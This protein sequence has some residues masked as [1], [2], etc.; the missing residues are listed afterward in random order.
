MALVL[1]GNETLRLPFVAQQKLFLIIIKVC[2]WE[3]LRQLLLGYFD[4]E[5]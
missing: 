2:Y 5:Y 4:N 1:A 3:S